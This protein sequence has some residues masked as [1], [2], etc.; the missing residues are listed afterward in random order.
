MYI[1]NTFYDFENLDI[2]YRRG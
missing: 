1:T 2:R